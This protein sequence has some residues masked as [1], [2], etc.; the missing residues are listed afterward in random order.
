M[1]PTD[2]AGICDAL[3]PCPAFLFPCLMPMDVPEHEGLGLGGEQCAG[4]ELVVEAGHWHPMLADAAEHRT[5]RHAD[6]GDALPAGRAMGRGVAAQQQGQVLAHGLG[7]VRRTHR[8]G[9]H[10]L[11]HRGDAGK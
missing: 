2:G 4:S 3:P 5:V 8:C 11:V 10:R 6:G 1:K 7:S 9:Y